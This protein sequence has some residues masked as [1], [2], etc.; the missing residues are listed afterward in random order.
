MFHMKLDIFIQG[1]ITEFNT[2]KTKNTMNISVN[3]PTFIRPTP[4]HYELC[5]LCMAHT[6]PYDRQSSHAAFT[7]TVTS[8]IQVIEKSDL[9]M[10]TTSPY[11]GHTSCPFF[12]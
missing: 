7:A 3:I 1:N 11:E 8:Y 9:C 5:F 2:A 4:M 12:S 10:E 6:C